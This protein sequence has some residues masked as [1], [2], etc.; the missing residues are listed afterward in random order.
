MLVCGGGQVKIINRLSEIQMKATGES[1]AMLED[2]VDSE[3]W[4]SIKL[5]K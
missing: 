5:T 3:F 2:S 4:E 1:L